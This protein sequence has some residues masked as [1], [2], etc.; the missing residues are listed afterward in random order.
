MPIFAFLLIVKPSCSYCHSG[1]EMKIR[2]LTILLPD[3][4]KTYINSI[5]DFG[6]ISREILPDTFT[7]N[8]L[9]QKPPESGEITGLSTL[10]LTG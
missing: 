6:Q 10:I 8:L 3:S 1:G 5:A 2:I 7:V 4:R 9:R